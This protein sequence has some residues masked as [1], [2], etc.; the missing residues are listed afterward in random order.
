MES[1]KCFGLCPKA[2]EKLLKNFKERVTKFIFYFSFFK[3]LPEDMLT[4]FRERGQEGVGGGGGRKGEGGERETIGERNI[5]WL[6]PVSF[7]TRNRTQN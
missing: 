7:P 1:K 4:D 3:Y 6:P 2:N 5:N